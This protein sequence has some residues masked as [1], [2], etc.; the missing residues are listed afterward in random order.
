MR[1]LKRTQY[2]RQSPQRMTT[3]SIGRG[4]LNLPGATLASKKVTEELLSVDH[5]KN[6][7][8]FRSTTLYNHISHHLLAAYDFGATPEQLRAIYAKGQAI[9]RPIMLD[10]SEEIIQPGTITVDNWKEYAR[11]KAHMQ[12]T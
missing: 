2:V 5:E 7:I 1:I 9:Q 8:Y 6:H 12:P 4:L 11:F 10:Q 3:I